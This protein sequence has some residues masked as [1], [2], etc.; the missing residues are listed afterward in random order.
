MPDEG[1]VEQRRVLGRNI[2]RARKLA[3][4]M[5]LTELA[6]RVRARDY[7]T[8][9]RIEAGKRPV[10]MDLLSRISQVTGVPLEELLAEDENA[11]M[12]R[13]KVRQGT[14]RA[15]W[16]FEHVT[17]GVTVRIN[18]ICDRDAH[19][20]GIVHRDPDKDGAGWQ[21]PAEMA[22]LMQIAEALGT[23]SSRRRS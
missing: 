2:A 11:P 18:F 5:T 3:G 1:L 14:C 21:S 22:E 15:S 6:E 20:L 10:S 12:T 7:I 16:T 17:D 8:L 13:S 19:G 4:D 23:P 9:S